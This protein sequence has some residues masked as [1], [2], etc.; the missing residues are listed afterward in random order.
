MQHYK[1]IFEPIEL[2][3]ED[4]E[5][6]KE[7]DNEEMN[8]RISNE[9]L[10]IYLQKAVS[11]KNL[12][13]SDFAITVKECLNSSLLESLQSEEK[14]ISQQLMDLIHLMFEKV[15]LLKQKELEELDADES[16]VW[17]IKDEVLKTL[18]DKKFD[19]LKNIIN[20][21][22]TEIKLFLKLKELFIKVNKID[23]GKIK[24]S[25]SDFMGKKLSDYEKAKLKIEKEKLKQQQVEEPKPKP[26]PKEEKKPKSKQNTDEKKPKKVK[27]SPKSSVKKEKKPI[28]VPEVTQKAVEQEKA[29][30]ATL[31]IHRYFITKNKEESTPENSQG[32]DN[33]TRY[34][35]IGGYKLRI[36]NKEKGYSNIENWCKNPD[37]FCHEDIPLK[38][39]FFKPQKPLGYDNTE[40][41]SRFVRFEDY[42]KQFT[43]HR[44]YLSVD[45]RSINPP[46]NQLTR[47][48]EMFNYELLTDDEL[49]LLDAESCSMSNEESDEDIAETMVDDFLVPDD[50]LSDEDVDSVKKLKRYN[51][52]GES[53]MS[54]EL[55]P[56]NINFKNLNEHDV[57]VQKYKVLNL[58]GLDYP[59]P[60]L[61]IKQIQGEDTAID[62]TLYAR[63]V[64][65]VTG[66][67]TKK[68]VYKLLSEK[69]IDVSKKTIFDKIFES[70]ALCYYVE[71]SEF[72][73]YIEGDY[74]DTLV[75]TLRNN[76]NALAKDTSTFMERLI[77]L[78]HGSVSNV[79]TREEKIYRDLKAFYP[80]V[81]KNNIE[82]T[83][84]RIAQV[85]Y[86]F[87]PELLEKLVK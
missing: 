42:M 59:L 76:N 6:L 82:K 30:K 21:K 57:L 81:T 26:Q 33:I 34:K 71:P 79:G 80:Q 51:R 19:L 69:G 3:P 72:E 47:M 70:A 67:Q 35:S 54:E 37:T 38:T 13:I 56:I 40:P 25:D 7:I 41:K 28:K 61:P 60:V 9:I 85:G 36:L 4:I 14:D 12:G 63:I 53:R 73:T 32:H 16:S 49:Q 2:E 43:E 74:Y 22:K 48:D 87:Y 64:L 29:K 1:N 45:K 52:E 20:H 50:Y 8:D 58:T 62:D 27:S 78:T 17:I 24:D 46:K 10:L 65:L 55:K 77:L 18:K 39:R 86:I 44:G 83:I 11:I 75:A 31:S 5:K 15:K 84:K 23:Q 68:D 66:I